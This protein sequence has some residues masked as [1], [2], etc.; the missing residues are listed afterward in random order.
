MSDH[1]VGSTGNI[2]LF[3]E[4]SVRE[5]GQEGGKEKT[6]YTPPAQ[7]AQTKEYT[8]SKLIR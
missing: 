7:I 4:T 6:I 2:F 1:H 8:N 5:L 3:A